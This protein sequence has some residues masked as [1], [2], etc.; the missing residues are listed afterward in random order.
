MKAILFEEGSCLPFHGF[1]PHRPF[2]ALNIFIND[3]HHN[4]SI[5]DGRMFVKEKDTMVENNNIYKRI[6]KAYGNAHISKAEFGRRAGLSSGYATD[7]ANGKVK[8]SVEMPD[9]TILTIANAL[10]VRF[11]W[12]KTGEGP[13][14]PEDGERNYT[15]EFQGPRMKEY[16]ASDATLD[17]SELNEEGRAKLK[18]H[19][20]LL[21][22][23]Y[24]ASGAKKQVD[25]EPEPQE[26]ERD[27]SKY[28]EA[29][30]FL[31]NPTPGKISITNEM[32]RLQAQALID[33]YNRKLKAGEIKEVKKRSKGV[34]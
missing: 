15:G 19:L 31:Y 33:E 12:L 25:I 4:L 16:V 1:R 8:Q 13:M 34:L 3:Y 7:L 5:F 20:I 11:H 28:E 21:L 23:A 6:I 22:K 18:E 14:L 26:Q 2:N 29:F 32:T 30:R 17:M 10:N 27:Y 24:P 9:R